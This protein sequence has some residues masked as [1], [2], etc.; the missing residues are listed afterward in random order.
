MLY[1]S[2]LESFLISHD[3]LRDD[4]IFRHQKKKQHC[5][6]NHD[7]TQMNNKISFGNIQIYRYFWSKL[8]L[9]QSTLQKCLSPC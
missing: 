5:N 7:T 4:K 3:A 2:P 1:P 8:F 6:T 9:D